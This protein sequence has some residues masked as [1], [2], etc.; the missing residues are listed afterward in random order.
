[1]ITRYSIQKDSEEN[2]VYSFIARIEF[3][4]GSKLSLKDHLILKTKRK[5]AYQ[6]MKKDNTLIIRWDNAPHHSH[7]STFPDH[8]HVNL[9]T[10]IQPSEEMTVSKVLQFIVKVIGV[11]GGL[12]YFLY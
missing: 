9:E 1:V 11:L 6:W 4:D 3:K 7:I 8:K 5:Y 2:G 10:N 12:L